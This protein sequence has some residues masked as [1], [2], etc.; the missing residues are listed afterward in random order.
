MLIVLLLIVYHNLI[1]GNGFTKREEESLTLHFIP[2]NEP[3]L[4]TK[5]MLLIF[6]YIYSSK[7]NL[8]SF[9]KK[10]HNSL[11]HYFASF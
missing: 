8:C 5:I 9:P 1:Y 2:Q 10:K 6:R 3:L 4:S 7:Y 11:D